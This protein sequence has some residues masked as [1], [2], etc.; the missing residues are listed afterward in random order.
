[1]S[2][3]ATAPPQ[4]GRG[5]KRRSG[6]GAALVVVT[7]SLIGA[8]TETRRSEGDDCLKSDDCLSGIC[9][10]QKCIAQPPLLEGGPPPLFEGGA[11]V[12]DAAGDESNAPATDADLDARGAG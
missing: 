11:D 6:A 3:R 4:C 8:C 5:Q 7:L 1:M 2:L 12:M 10:A 9:S